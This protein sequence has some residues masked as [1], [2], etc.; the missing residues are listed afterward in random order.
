MG[1]CEIQNARSVRLSSFTPTTQS[2]F[3]PLCLEVNNGKM[4]D[5]KKTKTPKEFASE[6]PSSSSGL[7]PTLE[8]VAEVLGRL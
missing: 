3:L 2:L 1:E 5:V 7:L 8:R 6:C 4:G